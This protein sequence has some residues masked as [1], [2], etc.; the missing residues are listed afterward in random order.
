ML[1]AF[2]EGYLCLL[3][4]FLFLSICR[5]CFIL[6]LQEIVIETV[7]QKLFWAHFLGAHNV[8]TVPKYIWLR[9]CN[10]NKFL[11][12]TLARPML[13]IWS[14]KLEKFSRFFEAY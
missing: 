5:L 12:V 4:R 14:N 7:L 13:R 2:G 3:Q 8:Q 1:N 6:F 10:D 11:S 9:H